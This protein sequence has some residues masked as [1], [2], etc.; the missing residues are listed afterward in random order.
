MTISD[1]ILKTITTISQEKNRDEEEISWKEIAV[2]LAKELNEIS[3]LLA[4]VFYT[5]LLN[6]LLLTKIKVMSANK[7]L[8]EKGWK[9]DSKG[10]FDFEGLSQIINE[11]AKDLQ[12]HRDTTIGL[13]ATDRPDLIEDPKKVMFEIT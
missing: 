13:W 5:V 9:S 6:R 1:S 8:Q 7:F 4:T 2:Q 12:S 3:N 10:M 11:Y